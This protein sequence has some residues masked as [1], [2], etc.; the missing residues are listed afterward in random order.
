MNLQD[1]AEQIGVT[2]TNLSNSIN[3]YYKENF[4]TIIN[5]KRIEEVKKRLLN[6]NLNN[7]SFL[8]LAKDCG[9]NSEASF[10]RIFK[11]TVGLTPK[12]YLEKHT[13]NS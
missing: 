6:N 9:F 4:R 12:Q 1:L 8:G 10:Y 7:L 11:K 13:S 2:E 5:K 3:A